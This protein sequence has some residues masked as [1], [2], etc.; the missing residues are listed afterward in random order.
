[1]T[2]IATVALDTN[3]AP[4]AT[5][6]VLSTEICNEAAPL[7]V[8]APVKVRPSRAVFKS[9]TVPRKVSVCGLGP[10]VEAK[11]RPAVEPKAS[12]PSVAVTVTRSPAPIA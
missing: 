7:K 5:A 1:M 11:V 3:D 2:L 6:A 8:G 12:V 9:A 10:G 4:D